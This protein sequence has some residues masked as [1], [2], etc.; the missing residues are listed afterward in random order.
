[1]E[2][3]QQNSLKVGFIIQAR[4]KS[5]RLPGKVLLPLP[6]NGGK[7]IVRWIVDSVRRS[8]FN[9]K[10]IIATS[11][12]A[13]NDPLYNYCFQNNIEC[14]RGDEENVLSRFIDVTEANGFDIVVRLTGDNPFVDVTILDYVISRH[15]SAGNDYSN[16]SGLPLGMNLEVVNSACLLQL[17]SE[18]LTESDY[19]HV[20]PF[21]RNSNK[22]RKETL[23]VKC[24]DRISGMRLTIDY[25][26]DFIVANS[27][28]N[29][30]HGTNLSLHT[31]ELIAKQY[32]W[33][34]D[35]NKTNIQKIQFE[36]FQA[37]LI[38]AIQHLNDIDLKR[39]AELLKKICEDNRN[40]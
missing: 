16:T 4:M 36:N 23:V 9:H 2:A 14:Y 40:F 32:S 6:L 30:I 24:D 39:T 33:L 8:Q 35:A 19:E 28:V 22:F 20:T 34:V 11:I 1:M 27:I 26:T 38:Y 10:V 7:P 25:P 5:S 31:L 13:E 29:L 17:K 3:G 15:C 12:D 18:V 21:I 37:E